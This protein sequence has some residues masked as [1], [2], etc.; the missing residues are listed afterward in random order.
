MEY[1]SQ[2]PNPRFSHS[3]NKISIDIKLLAYFNNLLS[4]LHDQE[5]VTFLDY[6]TLE[7]AGKSIESGI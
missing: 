1:T 2:S 3:S 5:Y 6:A 4:E 7:A